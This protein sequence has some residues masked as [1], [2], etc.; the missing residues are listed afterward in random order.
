[1]TASGG[2]ASVGWRRR[3]WMIAILVVA[4]LLLA[5][6]VGIVLTRSSG[7]SKNKVSIT[8]SI[9]ALGCGN[10]DVEVAARPIVVTTSNVGTPRRLER[11]PSTVLPTITHS[12]TMSPPTVTPTPSPTSTAPS[13][14]TPTPSS[15]GLTG[16]VVLPSSQTSPAAFSQPFAAVPPVVHQTVRG[17]TYTLSG[18]VKGQAYQLGA[19]VVGCP[20]GKVDVP[21]A[22]VIVAGSSP[23]LNL[24]VIAPPQVKK[25]T[26]P[27]GSVPWSLGPGL[28]GGSFQVSVGDDPHTCGQQPQGVLASGALTGGSGAVKLNS[29]ALAHAVALHLKGTTVDGVPYAGNLHLRVLPA[30]AKGDPCAPSVSID[31]PIVVG[32]LP[33]AG[34]TQL[35]IYDHDQLV[36]AGYGN[37]DV[38][39][40]GPYDPAYWGTTSGVDWLDPQYSNRPLDWS[41]TAPGTTGGIWQL[42]S[43]MLPNVC[44]PSGLIAS[45]AI[46][47]APGPLAKDTVAQPPLFSVDLHDYASQLNTNSTYY[48]RVVPT[49]ANGACTGA[50]SASVTVTYKATPAPGCLC[51]PQPDPPPAL[52]NIHTLITSFQPLTGPSQS[53]PYCF[54]ALA[55]H[56]VTTDV[57][58]LAQDFVGWITVG[59]GGTIA[60]GSEVCFT[61]QSSDDNSFWDDVV[62]IVD[63]IID[64]ISFPAKVYD[65]Y[66]QIIPGILGD[67]IP[68]C[69]EKCKSALLFAEKA[70][71]T[72]V[73]LPP[74]LPD[75]SRLV[76]DGEDYVAEQASEATG[77]P[78]EVIKTAY[79]AGK[80][81]LVAQLS[82]ASS[83]STGFPCDWCAFDN[84]TRAPTVNV[85]VSRDVSDD[86]ARPLPQRIC[87]DNTQSQVTVKS[88]DYIANPLY[89]GSCA[90]M[91]TPFPPGS[92]ISIP[93]ALTVNTAAIRWKIYNDFAAQNSQ[94]V[95]SDGDLDML[96]L[97]SWEGQQ[98]HTPVVAFT[99]QGVTEYDAGH[100]FGMRQVTTGAFTFVF[101]E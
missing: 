32:D 25:P 37:C 49:G 98:Q 8:G 24:G 43:T 2:T 19:K 62:S 31:V 50:A 65:L 76:N 96:A 55:D 71:L 58:Q 9:K 84:G 77:T 95:E 94:I 45:G 15:S 27:D 56:T 44:K 59:P 14:P 34:A 38:C 86:P 93:L 1:M 91:P 30:V 33:Q 74:S 79:N 81:A 41:S 26:S 67:L 4:L 63:V 3:R 57:L 40:P 87:V 60:K 29:S 85:L 66:E 23:S 17:G 99:S 82:A 70:A 97:Q 35:Q 39:Q 100:N 12:A 42:S 21:S 13:T 90:N 7:S 101:P 73:G 46:G 69:G 22:G 20:T 10:G 75:A 6:C 18:L 80:S 36:K 68:G 83:A 48:L 53:P 64:I 47:F 51:L 72:A 78:V 88:A 61:P 92:V 11:N 89:Y 54:Q 52:A 5:S 16:I 28:S